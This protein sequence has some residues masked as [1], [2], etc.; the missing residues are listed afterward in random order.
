MG[1]PSLQKRDAIV[2]DCLSHSSKELP[3]LDISIRKLYS[4]SYLDL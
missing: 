1:A 4:V 2:L 3:S